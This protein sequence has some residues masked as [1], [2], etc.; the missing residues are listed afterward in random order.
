MTKSIDDETMTQARDVAADLAETP[1]PFEAA[2]TRE[3]NDGDEPARLASRLV[4]EHPPGH[5][6]WGQVR[7]VWVVERFAPGDEGERQVLIG[8]C[9]FATEAAARAAAE[10]GGGTCV[11]HE[12]PVPRTVR[13][14]DVEAHLA[15]RYR[16]APTT[17][18]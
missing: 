6:T 17:L 1:H 18:E 4:H 9:W 2:T 13:S 5:E 10:R 14:G 8:W 12:T 15:G 7:P 3:V 11:V 16:S